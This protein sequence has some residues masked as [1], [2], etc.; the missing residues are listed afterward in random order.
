MRSG[1]GLVKI[2]Y[3]AV[4]A[5]FIVINTD[6]SGAGS[7]RQAITHANTNGNLAD[8]DTINFDIPASDP[9]CNATSGVCTISPTSALPTITQ[10][11]SIDGYSQPGA[12]PNTLA[13]G[14]NAEP[15]RRRAGRDR[16]RHQHYHGRHL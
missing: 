1:N 14:S 8:V 13:A 10:A 2:T 16:H 7:L 12:S 4:P 5:T 3:D 9:N 6:D 11:V 15:A